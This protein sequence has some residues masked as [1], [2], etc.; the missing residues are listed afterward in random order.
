MAIIGASGNEGM[1]SASLSS[2]LWRT[3]SGVGSDASFQLSDSSE[4]VTERRSTLLFI[5]MIQWHSSC[6]LF[7]GWHDELRRVLRSYFLSTASGESLEVSGISDL[8]VGFR[9][10]FERKP[11]TVMIQMFKTMTSYMQ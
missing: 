10:D 1:K 11:G 4:D 3:E 6:R 8:Y 7:E 5:T 2:V 9:S